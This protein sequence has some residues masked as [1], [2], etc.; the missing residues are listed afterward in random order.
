MLPAERM[1]S[2]NGVLGLVT[3]PLNHLRELQAK[4]SG[5]GPAQ[6]E[7]KQRIPLSGTPHFVGFAT[8]HTKVVVVVHAEDTW[9]LE[10]FDSADVCNE[11]S[12]DVSASNYCCGTLLKWHVQV[13]P[14]N[15]FPLGKEVVVDM[16]PNPSEGSEIVAL[17]RGRKSSSSCLD[18]INVTSS[19]RVI[20]W[21]AESAL[22]ESATFTC[23]KFSPKLSVPRFSLF[24]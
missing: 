12:G 10:I 9:K 5:D 8:S 23:R 16:Q 22:D 11:G 18:M 19:S 7:P 15:S 2:L 24:E 1:L 6:I 20:S 14:V 21:G 4:A 17:L 3:S 13:K